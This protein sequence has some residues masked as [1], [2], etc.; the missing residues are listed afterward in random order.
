ML[1]WWN[2][3]I[4]LLKKTGIRMQ[5]TAGG[6]QARTTVP[7]LLIDMCNNAWHVVWVTGGAVTSR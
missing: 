3:K 6:V 4:T 5:V 7:G 2:K 1:H